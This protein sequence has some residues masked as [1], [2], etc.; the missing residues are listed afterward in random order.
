MPQ[1]FKFYA[2]VDTHGNRLGVFDRWY[3][4]GGAD[5]VI[6]ENPGARAKGCQTIDEANAWFAG[7]SNAK[8]AQADYD[9]LIDLALNGK[10]HLLK[11][12]EAL[13]TGKQTRRAGE[14]GRHR[15]LKISRR[16]R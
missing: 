9:K 5:E 7:K 2:V 8:T 15:R 11:Q 16:M 13:L 10:P 3:G 14:I 12:A 4:V 1:R 6:E